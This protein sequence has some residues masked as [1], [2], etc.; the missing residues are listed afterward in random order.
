MND[1]GKLVY[2][3]GMHRGEDTDFYLKKGF[4]VAGFEADPALADFC[5][6][7]FSD[8]IADGKLVVI[9]G[10]IVDPADIGSSGNTVFFKNLKRTVW[11]TASPEWAERNRKLGSE[12]VITE[13]AAV[14]FTD[15]LSRLGIPYYLK[16]DIEGMDLVCLKSLS[17][18][19]KRPEYI[20]IESDKV[21][22][23]NLMMEF[24]LLAQLG[25]DSFQIVN[26]SKVANQ[27]EPPDSKEG[28]NVGYKFIRGA[29]GLFGNDLEKDSWKTEDECLADYRRIFEGYK[30]LGD[31]S[32]LNKS[33]AGR[34]IA[35]VLSRITGIPGWYDTHAR[36]KSAGTGS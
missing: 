23:D 13:V 19:T 17:G 28:H 11:G 14:S 16:T 1:S 5:R 8:F 12:F 33:V 34:M 6:R 29:S 21:S 7:R 32:R 35:R 20:S 4:R 26:Q 18:F 9:E 2:D 25:Y 30:W 22:F 36:H 15:C 31:G 3:V 27:K 24:R 10:A